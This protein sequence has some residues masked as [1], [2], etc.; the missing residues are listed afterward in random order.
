MTSLPGRQVPSLAGMGFS[1]FYLLAWVFWGNSNLG[2]HCFSNLVAEEKALHVSPLHSCQDGYTH[3]KP[4][5]TRV[6]GAEYLR[7]RSWPLKRLSVLTQ[8]E[9]MKHG[10]SIVSAK[11]LR[12]TEEKKTR[13]LREPGKILST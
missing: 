13:M 2:D 5:D 11:D 7:P 9:I 10:G 3:Y 1:F 8:K 12:I 6:P 4:Y